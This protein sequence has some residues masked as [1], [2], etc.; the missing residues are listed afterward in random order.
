MSVLKSRLQKIEAKIGQGAT[1]GA[2]A[3][4]NFARELGVIGPDED[5]GKHV[6]ECVRQGI[7]LKGLLDEID[8]TSIGP[9]SL[10]K[11]SAL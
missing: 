1:E 8:G 9:P 5:M 6:E 10:R 7:T 4:C 3:F 2:R 11:E